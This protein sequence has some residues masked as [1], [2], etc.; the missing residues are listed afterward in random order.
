MLK[1]LSFFTLII[2]LSSCVPLS[3]K[4]S[5]LVFSDSAN[6]SIGENSIDSS[7]L[8]KKLYENNCMS[9]HGVLEN[10]DK[11]GTNYRAVES[12]IKDVSSMSH[13]SFLTD[14]E[15][16]TII[17]ALKFNSQEFKYPEIESLC[18][19]KDDIEGSD[20]KFLTPEELKNT[21]TDLF[22][23]GAYQSIKSDIDMLIT[24]PAYGEF[25]TF[26]VS[27]NNLLVK[28]YMKILKDL[29]PHAVSAI[30]SEENC[31]KSSGD[32]LKNSVTSTCL[33]EVLDKWGFRILRRPLTSSE[34]D[35]FQDTY[36]KIDS[37]NFDIAFGG[38]LNTMLLNP[39]FL[40]LIENDGE[41]I[42]DNKYK[43]TDYEMASKLSFTL[44]RTTPSDELLL[45]AKNGELTNHDKIES[46]IDS[47]IND[48]RSKK[49]IKKFY[50]EWLQV[51]HDI[52][53]SYTDHFLSP[54]LDK[55]ESMNLYQSA[56]EELD[57]F[58]DYILFN[59]SGSLDDLF[60]SNWADLSGLPDLARVY[61]VSTIDKALNPSNR[62]GILTRSALHISGSNWKHPM[63]LGAMLRRHVL[64]D[65]LPDPPDDFEIPETKM[66][67]RSITST[68][69]RF[70]QLVS[71]PNCYGCHKSINGLAFA[72]EN[73]DSLGRSIDQ[74]RIYGPTANFIGEVSVN[75]TTKPFLYNGDSSFVRDG[76]ELSEKLIKAPKTKQCF[77][78]KI[79]SFYIGRELSDGDGCLVDRVNKKV[80]DKKS[81]LFLV[82]DILMSNNFK[83]KKIK[84]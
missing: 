50:K 25:S 11:M 57:R 9:C 63:K 30:R 77:S 10:S 49:I 60:L 70:E 82:K 54:T 61:G 71:S 28:N 6:D 68:R 81:L 75:T 62:S 21:I 51:E 35:D 80:V 13:L 31:L 44:L 23:V 55:M 74:E 46:H 42:G 67:L 18:V 8:G 58:L 12:A 53:D 29:V 19:D 64:C 4:K 83:M 73:I 84:Q 33:N 72:F 15:I 2:L 1:Q 47:L 79:T 38:V 17:E 39:N 20:S 52:V 37:E 24:E 48:S 16:T 56:Q 78:K 3:E 76:V 26:D 7:A 66:N 14:D 45:A 5:E 22:G 36:E 69:E 65:E 41:L 43:L 34:I 27:I 32:L 59:K 40:F